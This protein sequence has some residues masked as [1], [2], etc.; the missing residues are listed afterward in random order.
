MQEKTRLA[1]E[2]KEPRR[3]GVRR[4][5]PGEPGKGGPQQSEGRQAGGCRFGEYCFSKEVEKHQIALGGKAQEQEQLR[6]SEEISIV[7][8][9]ELEEPVG[10]TETE[11]HQKETSCGTDYGRDGGRGWGRT[12][13]YSQKNQVHCS[14]T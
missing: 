2:R 7:L 3:V 6:L 4:R 11:R 8:V 9:R 1:W 10:T 13:N 12:P 14:L 5:N